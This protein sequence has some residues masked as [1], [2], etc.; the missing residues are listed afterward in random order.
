MIDPPAEALKPW[1]CDSLV[2]R[3]PI[4]SMIRQPPLSVPSPIA[5]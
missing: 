4:V 1:C 2:M 5:M 3:V